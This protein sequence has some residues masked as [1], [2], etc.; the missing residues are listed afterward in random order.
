MEDKET[1]LKKYW[2]IGFAIIIVLFA[3]NW[4]L[5]YAIEDSHEIGDTFGVVNFV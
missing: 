1:S 3:G 2:F 5:Y 4:I